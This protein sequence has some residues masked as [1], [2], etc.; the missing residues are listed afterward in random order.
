MNLNQ[1]LKKIKISDNV[2]FFGATDRQTLKKLYQESSLFVLPSIE[3]GLS[4]V[5]AEAMASGL[6]V[7]CTT[8]TGG[9]D[10]IENGKQGFI[11]PIRDVDALA[12][13]ILW[14][15]KHHDESYQM[16][17]LGQEKAK[18]FSWDN[19]GEKVFDVYK[20]ILKSE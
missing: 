4:M 16:G 14:C 18:L 11:V 15:Y 3:E 6:P 13:K 17:L 10:L 1:V 20:K 2:K 8:N 12:E 7:V 9:E 5:I 19:Y